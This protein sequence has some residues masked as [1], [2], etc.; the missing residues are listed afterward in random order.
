MVNPQD[1]TA[2]LLSWTFYMLATNPEVQ[3]RLQEEVEEK[4][5]CVESTIIY[6]TILDF[7]ILYYTILCYTMLYYT[8]ATVH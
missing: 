6:Y 8:T 7:T 4:V 2:C 1:T 3:A 5:Y